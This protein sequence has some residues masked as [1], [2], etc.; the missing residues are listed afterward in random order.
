MR[1]VAPT[2]RTTHGYLVYP[3]WT[4]SVRDPTLVTHRIRSTQ[5]RHL[6]L[7]TEAQDSRIPSPRPGQ[8][9]RTGNTIAFSIALNYV[10]TIHTRPISQAQD[11]DIA[12]GFKI[13]TLKLRTRKLRTIC[14]NSLVKRPVWH[15]L[16]VSSQ[17]QFRSLGLGLDPSFLSLGRHLSPPRCI[18][19]A[20]PRPAFASLSRTSSLCVGHRCQAPALSL[21]VQSCRPRVQVLRVITALPVESV[22]HIRSSL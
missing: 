16:H 19:L 10:E 18:S 12:F 11:I 5:P 22:S 6:G 20:S 9:Q 15:P 3:A 13:S 17:F 4:T 8:H 2:R 1:P 21:V 7:K 14:I